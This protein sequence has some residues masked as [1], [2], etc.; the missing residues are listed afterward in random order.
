MKSFMRSNDEGAA[1]SIWC[2]TAPELTEHTGRYYD[3]C[4]EREPSALAKDDAL[5]QEL[6]QHSEDWS[7][8]NAPASA[9]QR[10]PA[11]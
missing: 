3:D 9:S 8:R 4:S 6:W 10:V 11:A 1:T 2:A 5:A 7:R